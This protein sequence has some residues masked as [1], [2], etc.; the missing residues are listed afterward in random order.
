[1][2]VDNTEVGTH[3]ELIDWNSKKVDDSQIEARVTYKLSPK[4]VEARRAGQA[5][6]TTWATF[7][8]GE[9]SSKLADP[10]IVSAGQGSVHDL[11]IDGTD[12]NE[13]TANLK[14]GSCADGE[15][16]CCAL[17]ANGVI[18]CSAC[19]ATDVQAAL[20]SLISDEERTVMQKLIE[21]IEEGGAAGLAEDRLMVSERWMVVRSF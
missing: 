11:G 14:H 19:V 2:E 5:V 8:Y 3:R 15:P 12:D 6:Q 16:A 18:D 10:S 9:T 7:H 4:A 20:D 21:M 13:D 17:E 1:V